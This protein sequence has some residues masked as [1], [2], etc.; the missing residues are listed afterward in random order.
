ML[1]L[2][3]VSPRDSTDEVRDV[4]CSDPAVY[5]VIVL[6]EAGVRPPGDVVLADVAREDASVIISRLRELGL[7]DR[8]SIAVETVDTAISRG[9]A[10]AIEAA[11]GEEADAVVWEQVE[12]RTAE[13]ATLSVGYLVFMVLACAIA[14]AG[15][16]TNSSILIVGA[17]VLG[18]EFGPIAGVC[19]AT[20]QRRRNLVAASLTALVV[21]VA[22][23]IASTF[24]FAEALIAIGLEPETFDLD[25]GIARLISHPDAYSAIVA[26]CAGIAGMLSLT[27]AKSGALIGVLV[28]VTTIPAVAEVGVAAAKSDASAAGGAAA[29]LG[30]NVTT[31]L[32]VGIATLAIQRAAYRRRRQR[33]RGAS[34]L[35]REL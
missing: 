3:I 2:R 29:Q 30:V 32:L 25:T 7:E 27:T 15:I 12:A 33:P 19:V 9:A 17:M 16:F 8:G 14:A 5:N 34:P 24:L 1:H 20:V 13:Q 31:I 23:A 26:A 10:Q 35:S 4:L 22:L 21:G 18:P 28:S 11:K 6:R